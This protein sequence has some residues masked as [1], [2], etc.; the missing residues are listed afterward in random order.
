MRVKVSVIMPVYNCEKYLADSIKSVLAQT[1]TDFE[2]III[3][4]GSK[5]KSRKIIEEYSLKDTRIKAFYNKNH[6]VS[7]T[8]NY[9]IDHANGEYIAFIDADDIYDNKYLEEMFSVIINEDADLVCCDL[10]M[11][12][13]ANTFDA[14]DK[15]LKYNTICISNEKNS[16]KRAI[17]LGMG[18]SASTKIFST[19]LINKYSIRFN[20]KLSYGEDMFFCWK[21][22]LVSKNIFYIPE[23]LYFYRLSG[24]TAVLRYHDSLYEKYKNSYRD[25]LDFAEEN[26]LNDEYFCSYLNMN[27]SQRL[28]SILKMEL[29]NPNNHF[30]D[31]L[32][33]IK[34][35]CDDNQIREGL[36]NITKKQTIYKLA[37][38]KSVYKLYFYIYYQNL[39]TKIVRKIKSN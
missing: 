36:E 9:G 25:M 3:D 26:S 7:F 11:G 34:M 6:G 32:K 1:F 10:I 18:I 15:N 23:K 20:E 8:R 19:E 29:K 27:F 31:K 39:R 2:L 4:D 30:F 37:Y 33:R 16:F 28:P 14:Q 21:M 17:D 24:D 38:K 22:F 13:N 5:D 12:Y 35:V